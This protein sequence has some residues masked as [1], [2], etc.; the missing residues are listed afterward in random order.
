MGKWAEKETVISPNSFSGFFFLTQHFVF[1][2]SFLFSSSTRGIKFNSSLCN[3][4]CLSV[5]SLIL[6]GI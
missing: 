3:V 5:P 1:L 6:L 2:A 4:L